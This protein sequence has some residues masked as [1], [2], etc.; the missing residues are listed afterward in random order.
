MNK[1]ARPVQ[2]YTSLDAAYDYFNT[3]LFGGSL[4][5]CLITYQRHKGAYGYFSP[6]R[7]AQLGADQVTDEI[8][9]N[10][11]HFQDQGPMNILSTLVHEQVHL[12]QEHFGKPPRRCYHNREW[13]DKMLEVG[14]VPST[15]GAKGGKQTGQ[16][17]SHYIEEG[18][19][20]ELAC[21]AWLDK[22]GSLF[23]GDRAGELEDAARKKK[24]KSKTKYSCPSCGANAW[25]KPKTKLLCGECEEAMES[26]AGASGPGS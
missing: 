25:A 24:A 12:W 9:L 5:P 6:K 15:T 11:A 13:A 4:P 8:A 26:E 3:K 20:F 17:C 2:T 22:Q 16:R 18:G 1:P 23:F 14:L 7:F 10:P 21:Q 19:P